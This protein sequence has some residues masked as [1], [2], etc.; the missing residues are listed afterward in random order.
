MPG[1]GFAIHPEAVWAEKGK[2]LFGKD[3]VK[4]VSGEK[5]SDRRTPCMR[6]RKKW[7]PFKSLIGQYERLDERDKERE[8]VP[9][10]EISLDEREDINNT[11]TSLRK[12]DRVKVTYYEDGKVLTERKTFLFCDLVQLKIRFKEGW[13]LFDNLLALSRA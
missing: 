2:A 7:L 1:K 12:K 10:P 13:L 8:K 9:R 3:K 11:L 5:Q 6:G 4:Y